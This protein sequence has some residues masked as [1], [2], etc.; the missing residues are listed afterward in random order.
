MNKDVKDLS[1]K[2]LQQKITAYQSVSKITNELENLAKDKT[3]GQAVKTLERLNK[4]INSISLKDTNEILKKLNN[5]VELEK[6]G[7][8]LKKIN[9]ML[10][11]IAN[12][13]PTIKVADLI[14]FPTKPKDAIPVVLTDKFKEEF[15]DALKSLPVY[16]GGGGNV[17]TSKL[18]TSKL[19]Q[20]IIEAIN[21]IE[22]NADSINLNTDDLEEK[23]DEIISKQLPDNHEVTISNQII[24]PTTPDDT[25]PISAEILPLPNGAATSEN[26]TNGSQKTQIVETIP[27]DTTKLNGSVAITETVDGTVTTK[28]ITKTINGTDYV[29]TVATDSSDN[30]VTISTW[31]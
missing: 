23:L 31:S 13:D 10:E 6:Q 3:V 14:K 7:N 8:E 4:L 30:S 17:D 27:T 28:T 15:Y 22:I 2:F 9:D 20:D 16:F 18:A 12:K 24:Q 5:S 19:Q 1:N 29:K 21:N 11:V 25:Q 26:Q